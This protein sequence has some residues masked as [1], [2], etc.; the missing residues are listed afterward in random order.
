MAF[1]ENEPLPPT[2][3]GKRSAVK[4]M[5]GNRKSTTSGEALASGKPMEGDLHSFRGQRNDNGWQLNVTRKV[6]SP[7]KSDNIKD[8]M[9]ANPE[10]TSVKDYDTVHTS[11]QDMLD[12]LGRHCG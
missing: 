8:P 9:P 1:Q 6:N 10:G 12:E 4:Q 5:F 11:H 3:D 2:S 7:N